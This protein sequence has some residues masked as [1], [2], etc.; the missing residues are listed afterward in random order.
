MWA[1]APPTRCLV[2]PFES[3]GPVSSPSPHL[4]GPL[5][6]HLGVMTYALLPVTPETPA[7]SLLFCA[8]SPSLP[9]LLDFRPLIVTLVL[10]RSS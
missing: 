9:A 2:L 4:A 6:S 5:S 8:A 1:G 10:R 3:K 7:P